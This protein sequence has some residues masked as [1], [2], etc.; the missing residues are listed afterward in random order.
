MATM[1]AEMTMEEALNLSKY[2]DDEAVAEKLQEVPS[3]PKAMRKSHRRTPYEAKKATWRKGK[4][5]QEIA[6]IYFNEVP[7]DGYLR[8]HQNPLAD[9]R[10]PRH[11]GRDMRYAEA[12]ASRM[13]DD[14]GM[15][16]EIL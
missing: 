8:H 9:Y 12:A 7:A 14:Y 1:T 4:Q 10:G 6:K 3:A 11:G 5:R 13:H 15:T 2:W 16:E